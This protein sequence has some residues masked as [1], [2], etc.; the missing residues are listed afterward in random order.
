LIS[1]WYLYASAA[2]LNADYFLIPATLALVT[3]ECKVKSQ[4]PPSSI[5]YAVHFQ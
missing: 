5:P 4:T 3:P 2:D 1:Y